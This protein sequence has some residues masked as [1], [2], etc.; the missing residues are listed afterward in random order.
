MRDRRMVVELNAIS[1][2]VLDWQQRYPN[3]PWLPKTRIRLARNYHRANAV[4]EVRLA[5]A[6][7][8]R[9]MRGPEP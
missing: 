2:E 8:P 5:A 1:E 9:E 6:P 7:E 3:D 4:T